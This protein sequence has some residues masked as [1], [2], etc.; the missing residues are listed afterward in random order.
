MGPD[1]EGWPFGRSLFV[2][3]IYALLQK[4][5]GVKH[6]LDVQLSWRAVIPAREKALRAVQ[7]EDGEDQAASQPAP[8]ERILKPLDGKRLDISVDT[9]LCSLDHEIQITELSNGN[10][11]PPIKDGT[12]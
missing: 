10:K 3:E 6:V 4:V 8:A 1:W 12:P 5:P 9:L 11:A 7:D 2:S